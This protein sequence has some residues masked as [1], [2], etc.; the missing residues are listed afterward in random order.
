MTL[1]KAAM[2][3]STAS[4]AHIKTASMLLFVCAALSGCAGDTAGAAAGSASHTKAAAL[5]GP[6]AEHPEHAAPFRFF[7]PTSFWNRR[8]G[9]A[10]TLD[11]NSRAVVGE[12]DAEIQ[13]EQL[14][15]TGP[16]I[17][18][19]A[20]SV[21]VYTVPRS[22]PTVRVHLRG[23][24]R[25]LSS[26]WRRVPLPP[27]AEPAAGSD[28][29]LA[30]WQPSTGRMWEFWRLARAPAG[31]QASWGGAMRDVRESPGVYGTGVW[32]RAQARWGASASS[33][34][35]LGGLISLEDLNAGVINHAL[36]MA[37]PLVRAGVY[38]S[39]AQRTD[40]VS[41]NPLALAEGAHL[42]LNPQLD[43]GSL[44]LPRLTLMIAEAAQRYGI[45]ITDTSP[46]VELYAQDPTPTGSDPYAGPGGYFEGREPDQL[47]AAF[48]WSELQLLAGQMHA[49]GRRAQAVRRHA[50]GRG[51]RLGAG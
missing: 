28:G 14:A 10:S 6:P 9:A 24:D 38:A 30:M 15:R 13:Q 39:P 43:L 25:S 20:Y 5:A 37:V 33:L 47:L 18:T 49:V 8:P 11:P 19:T 4:T 44:H 23:V 40:G 3:P 32:P 27:T 29:I 46:N 36:E 48:P 17:N 7:S 50:G 21:P 12:L 51:S 35:L 22:Q 26:A 1:L 42:R 2:R 41:Q 31:W 45:L 34:S 16:W